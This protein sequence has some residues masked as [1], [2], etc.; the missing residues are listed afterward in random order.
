MLPKCG[1]VDESIEIMDEH[2]NDAYDTSY[3][4]VLINS[5]N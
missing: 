2:F 3:L 4:I 5:L 1:P